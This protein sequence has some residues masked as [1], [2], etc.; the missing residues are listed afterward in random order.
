ML[1]IGMKSKD[2]FQQ[3]PNGGV[4]VGKRWVESGPD[5]V[6]K[7]FWEEVGFD[8]DLKGLYN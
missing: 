4:Q 6:K 2:G 8:L 1:S 3:M 7:D 5:I